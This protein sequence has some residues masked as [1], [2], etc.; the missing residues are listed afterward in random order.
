[1][2]WG[3]ITDTHNKNKI[4]SAAIDI[5]EKEQCDRVI[6][7]GDFESDR[8]YKR[9]LKRSF[10]FSFVTD[11][12]GKHDRKMSHR[13]DFLAE[14]MDNHR[15]AVF[16]DTYRIMKRSDNNERFSVGLAIESCSY[17]YVFYG[18]LHYF[19]LKIPCEVTS[20]IALNSGG[21]YYEDLS[22]FCILDPDSEIL[23]VYYWGDGD[24]A[25]ILKFDLKKPLS[26][27]ELV[28]DA[29][30]RYFAD[31]L[32]QYRWNSRDKWEY[33]FTEDE[34]EAWFSRNY[35]LLFDRLKMEDKPAFFF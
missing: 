5:F 24:F 14:R 18:H 29:A 21:F 11:H 22:T 8:T 20:A 19:N 23:D 26:S 9:F 12:E 17:D 25:H 27:F 30:A 34:D 31:A 33:A 16:H 4:V 2:K 15:V 3:I 6:H 10:S 32:R 1:M 13:N 28:N 35:K 7:C